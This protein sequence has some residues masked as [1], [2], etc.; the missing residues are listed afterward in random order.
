M[1]GSPSSNTIRGLWDRLAK[2]PLGRTAFGFA[3]RRIVPYSGSIRAEVLQ[4]GEGHALVRMRDRRSVRNHLGSI[5]AVA[6]MNLAEL[7]S[8]LALHY[9]MPPSA[10]AILTSFS[11]VYLKKARGPLTGESSVALPDWT[12]QAAIS[13]EAV[14]RD[15]SGDPVAR[16]EAEWLV[17]PLE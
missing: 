13:V 14:L 11:M 15:S 17:R 3:I 7:T 4:L 5:H 8:G 16:A 2:L 12:S 10:R 9:G 6:M 1:A